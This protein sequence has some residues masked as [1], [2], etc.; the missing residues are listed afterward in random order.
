MIKTSERPWRA[1]A[2]VLLISL[3]GLLL[4]IPAPSQASPPHFIPYSGRLTDGT[5]AGGAPKT[6]LV[7]LYTCACAS[8]DTSV[9][10]TAD[11]NKCDAEHDAPWFTGRHPGVPVMDGYFSLNIGER[12]VDGEEQYPLPDGTALPSPL[13]EKLWLTVSVEGQAELGPRQV[14]G[15][16][17]YALLARHAEQGD[18]SA[19]LAGASGEDWSALIRLNTARSLCSSKYTSGTAGRTLRVAPLHMSGDAACV[20]VGMFCHGLIQIHEATQEAGGDW[21]WHTGASNCGNSLGAD[22]SYHACCLEVAP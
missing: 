22:M 8:T 5:A 4:L 6:L 18:D 11:P 17:P 10:C 13:P 15:S 20:S 21:R 14:V 3:S 19:R 12:D 16:V 9:T 1:S 2:P 7:K